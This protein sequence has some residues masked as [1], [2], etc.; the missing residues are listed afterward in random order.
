MNKEY[1]LPTLLI[2]TT[3]ILTVIWYILNTDAIGSALFGEKLDYCNVIGCEVTRNRFF[4]V[5]AV[6]GTLFI[7]GIG[8]LIYRSITGGKDAKN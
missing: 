1:R 2:M 8:L 6:L 3:P 5:A 4:P 7:I